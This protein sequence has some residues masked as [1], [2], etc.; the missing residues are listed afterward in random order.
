MNMAGAPKNVVKF[1][2]I[3]VKKLFTPTHRRTVTFERQ[4]CNGK[5]APVLPCNV[6]SDTETEFP[7]TSAL[8]EHEFPNCHPSRPGL[9]STICRRTKAAEKVLTQQNSSF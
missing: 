2:D 4:H 5:N 1:I 9:F 3:T 6:I 7:S 8:H